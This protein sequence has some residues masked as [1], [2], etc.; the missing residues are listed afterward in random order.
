VTEQIPVLSLEDYRDHLCEV[1]STASLPARVRS[2]L[3]HYL[4]HG[5][6]DVPLADP[7]DW[8]IAVPALGD[9][10]VDVWVEMGLGYLYAVA[11]HA[12]PQ[13]ADSDA[14][15]RA[16]SRV[17][18]MWHFLGIDNA[19]Y[20][21]VLF[22]ALYAAAKLPGSRL[23]GLVVNEFYRLDGLKF[24]T[25]RDHAIWAHEF[26]GDEDPAM[27]RLYLCWD[28][29]DHYESDFTRDGYQSFRDWVT[30]LRNGGAGAG[31]AAAS[32]DRPL[33][34][35]LIAQ[36]VLRATE[37]LRLADFDPAVAVRCQLPVLASGGQPAADALALLTGQ[38]GG[39]DTGDTARAGS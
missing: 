34:P 24:S 33:P 35:A 6:P 15:A 18:R 8:G 32:P 4:A 27:V 11:R 36:N 20:F 31:S 2:L 23:G 28:R 19:F 22:P 12:D 14:F 26:F 37:S 5:L 9:Q 7:T 39:R 25:S 17:D 1:W 29:P 3:A 21:A 13:A 16:W 38:A 10:R 30:G